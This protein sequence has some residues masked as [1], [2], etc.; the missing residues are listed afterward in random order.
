MAIYKVFYGSMTATYGP[1]FIEAD[2]PEEAKRKFG[3]CFSEGERAICMTARELTTREIQ[4]A[5]YDKQNH[6]NQ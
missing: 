3:S 2:T 5:L 1:S 6:D 4:Q